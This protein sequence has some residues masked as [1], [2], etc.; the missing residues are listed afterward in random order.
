MV[1]LPQLFI[2]TDKNM[3]VVSLIF[4]A[5][6]NL[7][8]L[9]TPESKG[10]LVVKIQNIEHVNGKIIVNI[11]TKEKDEMDN[12]YLQKSIQISGK[13]I[14][15][16]FKDLPFSEYSILAI[17]DKND[18]GKLDH[19]FGF[20]AEPLGWSTG[21]RFSLFSGMPTFEKTKFT[22]SATNNKIFITLK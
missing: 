12:P 5:T 18:N 11:F 19:S 20:P 15:V 8:N 22:F 14:A 6:L 13:E 4:L 7:A 2:K 9:S 3:Y 10:D 17:H 16:V 1:F 21:W